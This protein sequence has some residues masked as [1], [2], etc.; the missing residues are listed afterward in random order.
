[1]E[2]GITETGFLCKICNL[3]FKG[4]AEFYVH[5]CS[6]EPDKELLKRCLPMLVKLGD[7]IGNGQNDER[8]I[9]ISEIKRCISND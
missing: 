3:E 8:C 9:L 6:G 7:F 2:M 1:M 4:D 5:K